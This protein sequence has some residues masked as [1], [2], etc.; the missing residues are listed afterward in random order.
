MRRCVAVGV[1]ALG[2]LLGLSFVPASADEAARAETIKALDS[3]K[4]E[5]GAVALTAMFTADGLNDDARF[6]LGI[7]RFVQ[8]IEHL[9]QG[10]YRYGL[11]P[12]RSFVMPIVRLPVPENPNP[13]PVDYK[14]FREILLTFVADLTAAE[15]VL[16]RVNASDVKIP[17]DLSSVRYDANGDGTI[18]EDERFISVMARVMEVETEELGHSDTLT[19]AFDRADA[20]WLRGYSHVLMALGEFLLAYDWHESFDDSF[21]VFFPKAHS[22]FQEALAPP[23]EGMFSSEVAIADLISFLHIRWPIAEPRR[24]RAVR[25]H[26]KAMVSL[27]RDNWAAI[28]AETDNDREWIPNPSQKAITGTQI[29]SDQIDAWHKVLDEFDALLDGDKL[30]PHWRMNQGINLRKVFEKPTPFDL[31]LWI[32]GPATMPYLEDGP[33][34]TS[35]EWEALT[36]GFEDSFGSYAIWFN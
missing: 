28:M 18:G 20:F 27:S 17:I 32:T 19:V 31:V 5:D 3:G 36:A 24:M 26:L 6:G 14:K 29:T 35:E 13:E 12:P 25:E 33:I 22:P 9:S 11:Q 16:A 15:K 4:L 7:I 23:G 10:L 8:A 1:A 21:H 30:M 34:L 2:L